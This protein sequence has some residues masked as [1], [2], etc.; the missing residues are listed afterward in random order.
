MSS[1][2][3]F[4]DASAPTD[5][6]ASLRARFENTI[7]APIVSISW[8]DNGQ[9]IAG[10]YTIAATGAS[11]VN[12]TPEDPKNEHEATGVT[13]VADGATVNKGTLPGVG[14]VFSA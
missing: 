5:P 4:R 13:V 3:E 7:S 8:L 11:T 2:I 14:I 1:E 12:V 10:D 6:D 9:A